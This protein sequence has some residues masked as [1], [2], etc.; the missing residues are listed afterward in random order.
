MDDELIEHCSKLRIEVTENNIIDIGDV[1]DSGA[2]ERVSLILVGRLVTDRNYTI[3]AFKR[4]MTHS[5]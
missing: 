3:E 2:K 5:C 1:D 4:T